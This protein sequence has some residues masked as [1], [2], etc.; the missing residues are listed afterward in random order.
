MTELSKIRAVAWMRRAVAKA[1]RPLDVEMA[2][3][4]KRLERLGLK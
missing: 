4:E 1:S 3:V 2:A